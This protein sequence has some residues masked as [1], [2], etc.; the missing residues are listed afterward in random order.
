MR[1]FRGCSWTSAASSGTRPVPATTFSNRTTG[2]LEPPANDTTTIYG[3][4]LAGDG[5]CFIR[6]LSAVQ[7]QR[8]AEGQRDVDRAQWRLRLPV[9]APVIRTGDI[10]VGI[11]SGNDPTLV[12]RRL[13]VVKVSGNTLAVS[14]IALL[15]DE[16]GTTRV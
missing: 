12:G 10:W 2:K 13:T 1:S 3:P 5:R 14:R 6:E 7:G 4:G 16:Q 15:Q 11:T 8:R 9:S